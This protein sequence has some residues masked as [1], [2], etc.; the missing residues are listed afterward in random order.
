M[1]W[2]CTNI[3]LWITCVILLLSQSSCLKDHCTR[4]YTIYTPVY[5]TLTEVRKHMKSGAAQALKQTGKLYLYGKYIFLN[6]RERGIHIIDNSNPAA[7]KNIAFINIPGNV[8]L[9][10]KGNTLYADSWSD[11]VTFDISN[12]QEITAK[13]F[14]N[15]VFP[16]RN[17][18][19]FTATNTS[20]PD[21]IKV[22]VD[23][24]Q[25]DTTVDCG[26]YQHLYESYYAQASADSKGN[27]AVP[28][29]GGGQ[30]G[31]MARFTLIND[32]L[33]TVT[34]ATLNTFD[35]SAAQQPSFIAKTNLNNWGIET[36]FPFKDKLFIGSNTGM[37]IYSIS[38]PATPQ[39]LG[40]FSHVRS[41]DPV[42]ADDEYAYVT[43]RSG[44][45]CQGFSNQLEILRVQ[46]PSNPSMVKTY[47]MSNPHG[48]AKDNDILFICDGKAG[49]KVYDAAN[50]NDLK[51]LKHIDGLDAYDVIAFNKRALVVAQDG[52]Y[53]FNYADVSNIKLLSKI[54]L[55]K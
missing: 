47:P 1:T 26:T 22:V 15:N 9:A 29:L 24:L 27:Y 49:V 10:V 44:T 3:L 16:H 21:S 41:C 46:D 20:N 2:K 17:R 18:Y 50:V 48:L 23:W 52:L 32:Y 14:L 8:D 40:T 19:Y 34:D 30:G 37:Y 39:V 35:V 36:I 11:L 4:T 38:N 28:S 43:L 53:Q 12:P 7:P 42:I 51:L 33:Y 45:A 31:S 25:R 54:N 5:S 55:D 13:H 6:E